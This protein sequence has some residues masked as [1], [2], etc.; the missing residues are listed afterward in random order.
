[1]RTAFFSARSNAFTKSLLSS[2]LVASAAA[3]NALTTRFPSSR[4]ESRSRTIW[5]NRRVTR[6]RTTEF[7]TALDTTNPTKDESLVR[8]T[9]TTSRGELALAPRRMVVEK[10]SDRRI[11]LRAGSTS[12]R[13]AGATL[14]ATRGNNRAASTGTHTHTESVC[15]GAAPVVR[16][17]SALAHGNLLPSTSLRYRFYAEI[18]VDSGHTRPHKV[19]R[20]VLVRSTWQIVQRITIPG[21]APTNC[22][23]LTIIFV[24]PTRVRRGSVNCG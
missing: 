2:S 12:G 21:S 22:Q 15:L 11:R 14:T 7:P 16:L 8:S 4:S 3:G 17:V 18:P 13:Q 23:F 6:C 24:I 9:C 5:R 10:S 19:T 20:H 1:M